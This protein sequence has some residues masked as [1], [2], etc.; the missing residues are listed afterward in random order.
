VTAELLGK[1]FHKI[2]LLAASDLALTSKVRYLYDVAIGVRADSAV[3]RRRRIY[4]LC[5]GASVRLRGNSTDAKV[6]EEVFL[7]QAYAPYA[8]LYA[9]AARRSAPTILIDL[10]ANIGLSV[11]A[12]AREL[13]PQAIV[14]VEP[15]RGNFSLLQQNLRGS[16]WMDRCVAVQAFAGAERGF[17]ELVDSSNGAWGMR[18]GPAARTGIPVLPLEEIIDMANDRL[19]G[20]TLTQDVVIPETK[21]VLK[22]DIEGAELHLF[23]HL[24][25]WEDRVH[26]II[27]EL[28]TEFF[29]VES[30][31]QCLEAPRYYW[32][33]NGEMLPDA[34]LGVIGLERLEA[35]A[36]VLRQ[37]A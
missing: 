9:K 10:G 37:D 14:A 7:Q 22:C 13:Q 5:G 21:L 15:D 3:R 25:K 23:R 20:G 18:M 32:R 19:S 28:H 35:K 24:R 1:L 16:G 4:R 8:R 12:L 2:R 17:A 30:L 33:R 11:I 31:Q 6:F 29:S 26:Y 36:T 27:L 34:V